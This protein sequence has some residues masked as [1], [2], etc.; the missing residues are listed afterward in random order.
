MHVVSRVQSRATKAALRVCDKMALMLIPIKEVGCTFGGGVEVESILKGA[1][2]HVHDDFMMDSGAPAQL[3]GAS[4]A[5][6]DYTLD[7]STESSVWTFGGAAVDVCV[8]SIPGQP[9]SSFEGEMWALTSSQ[10][11]G[12]YVIEV[13]TAFGFPPVDPVPHLGDNSMAVLMPSGEV[14]VARS[15]YLLRRIGISKAFERANVYKSIKVPTEHN[16][17][18]FIGKWVEKSKRD[19]SIVWTQGTNQLPPLA[20]RE[21][22]TEKIRIPGVDHA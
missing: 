14:S 21:A 16:F 3:V 4:D 8:H 10:M 6:W 2:K 9:M 15:K 1:G 11:R 7:H 12:V 5:T 20:V 18:D 19:A 13:A 22:K 17:S